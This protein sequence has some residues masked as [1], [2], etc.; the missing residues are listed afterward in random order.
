[1]ELSAQ[2][3]IMT[4]QVSYPNQY[5]QSDI[6]SSLGFDPGEKILEQMLAFSVSTQLKT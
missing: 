5:M 6:L 4:R 2:L 3:I 1:M